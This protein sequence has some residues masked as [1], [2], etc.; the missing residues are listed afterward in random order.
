MAYSKDF[1]LRVIEYVEEGL[2]LR[3]YSS[4]YRNGHCLAQAIQGNWQRNVE[5]K[6][7]QPVN[8]KNHPGKARRICQS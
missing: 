2:K 7:W 5:R 8:K 1:G 6:G 3:R 4:V